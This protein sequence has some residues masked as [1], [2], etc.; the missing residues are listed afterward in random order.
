MA[1]A[2]RRQIIGDGGAPIIKNRSP[3]APTNKHIPHVVMGKIVFKS[4]LKIEN[5]IVF[6]TI[7]KIVLQHTFENY[8][9]NRK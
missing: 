3:A 1:S 6:K 5:K 2:A 4:I 8:F 9:E 7:F